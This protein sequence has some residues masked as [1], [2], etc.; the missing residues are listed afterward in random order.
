LLA[1]ALAVKLNLRVRVKRARDK[2]VHR[3]A[4]GDVGL[5]N[6]TASEMDSHRDFDGGDRGGFTRELQG[7]PSSN[8]CATTSRCRTESCDG[9][10]D[11]VIREPQ[12][13]DSIGSSEK[14]KEDAGMRWLQRSF[15]E[16]A[17][18]VRGGFAREPTQ[19]EQ[20]LLYSAYKQVCD[21]DAE[22]AARSPSKWSVKAHAKWKAH[23]ARRGMTPEDAM[24]E[25]VRT[26]ADLKGKYGLKR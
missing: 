7:T 5:S 1:L 11:T 9:S 18:A 25:Y 12:D 26:F 2:R 4:T 20:L 6:N 22:P 3:A 17:T 13:S 15:D 21:G 19:S 8:I 10:S 16:A 24:R 23:D 14:K